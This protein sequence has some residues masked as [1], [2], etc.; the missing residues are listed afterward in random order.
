APFVW[1]PPC[2]IF[3]FGLLDWRRPWRIAHLDLLV[4]LAFGASHVFFNRGE[5][6]VS[7]PLVYPV[8][9]YLLGRPLGAGFRPGE[10]PGRL[11]PHLPLAALAVALVLLVGL[12]VTLNVVD[13]NV[14][15]VGYAG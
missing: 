7:A 14:I 13:S 3:V 15:D 2:A 12:R 6:G 1:V 11:V 5:I 8:L 4:L 10:R 9:L